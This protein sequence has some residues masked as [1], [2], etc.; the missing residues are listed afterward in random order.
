MQGRGE[1]H[2][3]ILLMVFKLVGCACIRGSRCQLL[4][5]SYNSQFVC[6]NGTGVEWLSSASG[7]SV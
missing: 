2:R 3:K 1:R 7:A 4:D 6:K 5:R